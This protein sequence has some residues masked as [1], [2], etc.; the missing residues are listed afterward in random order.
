MSLARKKEKRRPPKKQGHLTVIVF[1]KFGKPRTSEI[2]P[3]LVLFAI[4]F[5]IFYIVAT[6]FM[7]N[8]YFATYSANKMQAKKIAHLSGELTRIAKSLERSKRRIAL[9]D[10]Y[11]KKEK[12]QSSETMP[13]GG[14]T[15][16]SLP[17]LVRIEELTAGRD[18]PALHVTFKVVNKQP[19]EAPVGG[20]I[21]VLASPKDQSEVWV[22]PGSPIKEGLPVNYTSGHRFF[23]QNF[24]PISTTLNLSESMD[25][26]LTLEILVYDTDGDLV[27]KKAAEVQDVS[28]LSES[29][30]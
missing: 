30:R 22:Y 11:I 6:I 16:P 29:Y 15:E 4:S 24:M 28:W 12:G 10:E 20:Y 27:L 3:R 18:G 19:D 5:L 21:F 7:T 9:L 23:I 2:S 25:E 26:P 17:K 8:K 1:K 13:T 14:S